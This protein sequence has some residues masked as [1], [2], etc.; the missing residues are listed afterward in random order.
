MKIALITDTHAGVRGDNIA[1]LDH[2][3]LFYDNVFFPKLKQTGIKTVFHLGDLVDRRK[4]V[5][6]NTVRRLRKDFIEPLSD[7]AE[8]MNFIVGNHDTFYKDTNRV[9]ALYE[10]LG[11]FQN[12]SIHI[13]PYEFE[14]DTSDSVLLVPW[15]CSE[16]RAQSFEAIKT[17]SAQICMGHLEIAGFEMHRGAI[18]EHGLDL[19]EFNKFDMV[20]S[21]HFHHKSTKGNIHYLGAPYEMTWSDYN[22]P[23][24]FHIFDTQTRE[25]EFVKNPYSLFYKIEYDDRNRTDSSW[26]GEIDFEKYRSTYVKV[27]VRGKTN[28]YWFDLFQTALEKVGTNDIK[29]VDDNYN[30]NLESDE[31]IIDQAED[32]FVILQKVVAQL[33][34]ETN[35]N[36]LDLLLRNLYNEAIN[37]QV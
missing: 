19:K 15:I 2:Q 9:N 16:N 12:I 23:R 6:Y 25:L 28:P 14:P 3:K 10:I 18:C 26:I 33:G 34:M 36:K 30:L 4:F 29:V 20:M 22:D 27:I 17:T 13:K 31:E 1:L 35:K 21:G 5:N 8:R 7:I 11:P 37:L 24:G 32:T